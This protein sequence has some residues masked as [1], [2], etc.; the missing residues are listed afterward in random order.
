MGKC[1]RFDDMQQTL[2]PPGLVYQP[3]RRGV[4]SARQMLFW[5]SR[6]ACS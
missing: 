6:P 5:V 1:L 2:V 4:T 3:S